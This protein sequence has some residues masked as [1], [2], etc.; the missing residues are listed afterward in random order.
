MPKYSHSNSG[1]RVCKINCP[2][3]SAYWLFMRLKVWIFR[4]F[5]KYIISCRSISDSLMSDFALTALYYPNYSMSIA[6]IHFL[7]LR[8]VTQS[9]GKMPQTQ[10]IDV[11]DNL[12]KWSAFF[13]LSW[14]QARVAEKWFE[15]MSDKDTY[16]ER[17]AQCL[18]Q[19]VIANDVSL[20]WHICI[21]HITWRHRHLLFP[22]EIF[23][24]LYLYICG[25]F[26]LLSTIKNENYE[27]IN[28][29][30]CWVNCSISNHTFGLIENN[31]D[32]DK[33][34]LL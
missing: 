12:T 3:N 29:P 25:G 11:S 23:R 13:F 22:P 20:L 9:N 28:Y 32:A 19:N 6:Y 1:Y 34:T 31:W 24:V 2:T 21:S 26:A 30:Y 18:M 33:W 16:V 8:A 27:R 17:C 14:V 4:E 7:R 5:R 10:C 15:K